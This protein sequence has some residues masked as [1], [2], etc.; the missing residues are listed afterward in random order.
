MAYRMYFDK[1]LFPVT[2]DT[3]SISITNQNETVNLINDGEVN[4]LKKPGLKTAKF[5]LRLPNQ[6]YHFAVY[7]DGFHPASYYI[8][9][10]DRLK[11]KKKNFQWILTR[12]LPNGKALDTTNIK[13][14]IEDYTLKE[15]AGQDGFDV[16]VEINLKE[17]VQKKAKKIKLKKASAKA[18]VSV[19][20][21]RPSGGNSSDDSGSG[22]GGMES[23]RVQIP[24]MSVVTVQAGSVQGAI[25]KAAGSNWTGT[26]YVNNVAYKVNKG[27][28]VTS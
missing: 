8:S 16:R 9:Q 28:I 22:G 10:I 12:Q 6:K 24:G 11:T 14:V 17:Y 4:V 19:R 25:T 7:P 1:L 3:V 5:T 2:P 21:N 13:M 15:N 27:K 26:I 20:K 18:P 23:Y